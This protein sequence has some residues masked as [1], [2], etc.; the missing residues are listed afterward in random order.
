M[1]SNH[2]NESTDKHFLIVGISLEAMT[3]LGPLAGIAHS[4]VV[5]GSNGKQRTM[6]LNRLEGTPEERP[7]YLIDVKK[8]K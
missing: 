1:A 2:G 7:F 5:K 8:K 3:A 6:T 4:F